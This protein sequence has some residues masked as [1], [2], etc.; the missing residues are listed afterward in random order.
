MYI[1][2]L[3]VIKMFKNKQRR[4]SKYNNNIFNTYFVS[5]VINIHYVEE[6]YQ[7][8]KIIA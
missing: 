7:V 4:R 3:T 6:I 2:I 8:P 5:S 1:N